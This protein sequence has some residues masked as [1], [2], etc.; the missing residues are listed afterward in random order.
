MNT[1]PQSTDPADEK[2]YVGAPTA[3]AEAVEVFGG[4][5]YGKRKR[6]GKRKRGIDQTAT[7]QENYATPE[8]LDIHILDQAITT[9]IDMREFELRNCAG[10]GELVLTQQS[11]KSRA[12]RF[13]WEAENTAEW[14]VPHASI[15]AC[16]M[17]RCGIHVGE[18][19]EECVSV[20]MRAAPG[21]IVV[22]ELEWVEVRLAGEMDLYI[23]GEIVTRR[24]TVG[25]RLGVNVTSSRQLD[26]PD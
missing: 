17:T 3:Y 1:L 18:T 21:T 4:T 7:P 15:H 6:S 23:A 22:Y 10:S 14:E 24:F 5:S 26:C 9:V 16:L 19:M 11:T 25:H 12:R 2:G 13:A 8:I 20:E